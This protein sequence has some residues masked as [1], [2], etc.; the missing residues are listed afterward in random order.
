MTTQN[1]TEYKDDSE[2][3]AEH[4]MTK[5]EVEERVYEWAEENLER[6]AMYLRASDAVWIR[7]YPGRGEDGEVSISSHASTGIR[8]HAVDANKYV[9]IY[10]R[11]GGWE[12][13]Y[14]MSANISNLHGL[15][16]DPSAGDYE[17]IEEFGPYAELIARADEHTGDGRDEEA[18][19]EL[20]HDEEGFVELYRKYKVHISL[21]AKK[22][23]AGEYRDAIEHVF[24]ITRE[25]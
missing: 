9:T 19:R 16:D 24:S 13:D 21:A 25:G 5:E 20:T 18:Y 7:Y 22:E 15:L 3:L 10:K 6:L 11:G 12:S 8:D 1:E 2:I 23:F 4:D 17:F 14:D